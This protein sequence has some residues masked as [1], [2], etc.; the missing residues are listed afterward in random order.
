M[1]KVNF[2]LDFFGSGLASMSQS[3]QLAGGARI[4][5]KKS[6]DSFVGAS[7]RRDYFTAKSSKPF[8][9]VITTKADGQDAILDG[10]IVVLVAVNKNGQMAE[11]YAGGNND[12]KYRALK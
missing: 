12:I 10:E 7:D 5:V 3:F 1:Y 2:S 4:R 6:P 8:V 9:V 11:V